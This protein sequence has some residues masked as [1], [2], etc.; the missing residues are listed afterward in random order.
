MKKLL[1]SICIIAS[2]GV[3]AQRNIDWSTDAILTP[4]SVTSTASGTLFPLEVVFKNNGTSSTIVGDSL[5]W[6]FFIT[7]QGSNTIVAGYPSTNQAQYSVVILNRV[8]APGDTM[9]FK[10]TLNI[11]LLVNTSSNITIYVNSLVVNRSASNPINLETTTANNNLISKNIVW[12]N[13]QGWGV[14]INETEK[15]SASVKVYPNPAKDVINFSID[16]NVAKTI[17]VMD[18][19]GRSIEVVRINDNDTQINISNYSN[20]IY[21]YQIKSEDG[22]VI[23]SGK[24]NVS[25]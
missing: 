4:T 20:G 9:H 2:T 14:G 3:F 10:I 12:Y 22:Q 15:V 25:K 21:L 13:Q 24:F 16:G 6:Q 19:T 17:H 5:W 1:L 23:K 8:L 11:P 18:I 7:P